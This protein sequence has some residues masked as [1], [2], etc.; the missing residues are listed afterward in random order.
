M[1]L[2]RR[3][4]ERDRS[5][6][7]AVARHRVLTSDQLAQMFFDTKK[8]TQVRLSTL[9]RLGLLDRFQP[10]RP[11]WGGVCYHYVIG[12]LGASVLA[13]EAGS[14]AE[15][16]ARRWKAD[17]T[18]ALAQS[19][20]LAHLLGVNAFY[21]SLVGHA[22]RHEG[23]RLVAWMTEAECATWTEGIVRPDAFGEW[24]EHG[25]TAQLR[26]GD[27]GTTRTC[28]EAGNC[29]GSLARWAPGGRDEPPLPE[30]RGGQTCSS[31]TL[32]TVEFFLEYDRGTETLA[33]LVDKLAGYERLEAERGASSWVLF[34][35]S[36]PRREATARRALAG[37]TVPIATTVLAGALATT[38]AP[39]ATAHLSGPIAACE[40]VWLP[41]GSHGPRVR[42]VALGGVAKP[43]EAL[44]R[45]AAG[46]PRAW[47]FERSR[48]DEEEAPIDTS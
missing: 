2:A 12:P 46:G 23:T 37:A 6:L 36:S 9:H 14:D 38:T 33:R 41:L 42:L 15:R 1:R 40:A 5:I 48:T 30:D 43:T 39:A 44:R 17:R 28:Q 20:R 47:R 3:L 31:K 35:L 13:A 10:H 19:Q 27:R 18:L 29:S 25:G 32:S 34:V 11:N 4:T 8:R 22:R 7:R 45:A 24:R 26:S 16:A 21:A